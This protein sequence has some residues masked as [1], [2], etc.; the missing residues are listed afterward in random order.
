M[1]NMSRGSKGNPSKMGRAVGVCCAKI[2][3]PDKICFPCVGSSR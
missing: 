3:I 2:G 1:D